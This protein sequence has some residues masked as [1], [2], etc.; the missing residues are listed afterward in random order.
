MASSST[1]DEFDSFDNNAAPP[2]RSRVTYNPVPSA[3]TNTNTNTN[4]NTTTSPSNVLLDEDDDFRVPLPPRELPPTQP[5]P[6][7]QPR[8]VIVPASIAEKRVASATTKKSATITLA[9]ARREAQAAGFSRF[10]KMSKADLLPLLQK[11]KK[12]GKI[13]L[14]VRPHLASGNPCK[15]DTE[16]KS[17]RC[18]ENVCVTKKDLKRKNGTSPSTSPSPSPAKPKSKTKAKPSK[19][20]TKAKSNATPTNKKASV[21]KEDKYVCEM[22]CRRK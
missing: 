4:T 16:C 2:V 15:Q 6:V 22:V 14:E 13:P 10:W 1:F 11:Y 8:P 20:K 21:Q 5:R 18:V 9:E 19:T 3:S 7:P 17:K 12:T